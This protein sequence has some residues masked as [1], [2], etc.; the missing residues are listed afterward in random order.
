MTAALRRVTVFNP[1]RGETGQRFAPRGFVGPRTLNVFPDNRG[2]LRGYRGNQ[3]VLFGTH[4]NWAGLCIVE[5]LVFVNRRGETKR[6]FITD[7]YK[8]WSLEGINP[9]LIHTFYGPVKLVAFQDL[10][11]F[12]S[13]TEPPRKWDGIEAV[14]FLGIREVPRAP[15]IRLALGAHRMWYDYFRRGQT[16]GIHNISESDPHDWYI[17]PSPLQDRN[18]VTDDQFQKM[19]E[20][21]I[22]FYNTRGQVGRRSAPTLLVIPSAGDIA[23]D[24]STWTPADG[25]LHNFAW[26]IV[27]WLPDYEQEDIAGVVVWRTVNEIVAEESGMFQLAYT[28]PLPCTRVTDTKADGALATAYDEYGGYPGPQGLIGCVFHDTV[29]IA[30]DPED[31]RIVRWSKAGYAEDWP[32]LN[33][34][35]ASD[36]ITALLP[37]SK[38]VVVVTKSSI[39]TLAQNEDGTFSQARVEAT[40]GSIFGRTLV[41]YKDNVIGFWNCGFGIFDGFTFKQLNDSLGALSDE[42]DVDQNAFAWVSPDGMFF[43]ATQTR[44]VGQETLVYH[45]AFNAW[46]RLQQS[47]IFCVFMEDDQIYFG[48]RENLRAFN[49]AD[50]GSGSIEFLVGGLEE[51]APAMS[52]F[53]KQLHRLFFDLQSIGNWNYQVKAYGD[54]RLSRDPFFVGILPAKETDDTAFDDSFDLWDSPQ[55]RW[56]GPN[57]IWRQLRVG[58][59]G[60][61]WQDLRVVVEWTGD[62]CLAGFAF[63]AEYKD[64]G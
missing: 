63:E 12:L 55:A 36:S 10:C 53:S 44:G 14:T 7:N 16:W 50:S 39:E 41:V 37:L 21:S 27:E 56:D 29:L 3:Q 1:V 59:G 6:V 31:P 20:W 30:G 57:F 24:R 35:R 22:S 62:I 8:A 46:F 17:P 4:A 15:E 25:S 58:R 51:D 40:K 32:V 60:E 34:Y 47:D 61:A 42:I 2:F 5:A 45:F 23:A 38:S 43:V 26:P 11:L 48:G 18:P 28:I 49:T 13:A 9:V 33:A 54:E 52:W 19:Y 64:I